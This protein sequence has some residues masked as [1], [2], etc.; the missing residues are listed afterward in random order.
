MPRRPLRPCN[1]QGCAKLTDNKW[2]D[3][4][5]EAEQL[6]EASYSKERTKYYNKENRTPE[7]IAFYN[8]KEWK[9]VRILAIKRDHNLC[10]H[11]LKEG[12]YTM[13]DVVDHRIELKDNFELRADL[14]NLQCLCHAC[15]NRKTQ[16]EKQKRN[17]RGK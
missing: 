5:I 1:K 12:R 7:H 6:K 14:D 13:S 16:D 9:A 8:S 15:H 4:H 10:Q 3:R 17:Q 2:C 11:C